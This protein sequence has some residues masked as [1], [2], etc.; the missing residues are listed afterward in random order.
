MIADKDSPH[1]AGTLVVCKDEL[2]ILERIHGGWDIP[3]GH[4]Q[5]GEQPVAAAMREC[6]EETRIKLP[7]EPRYIGSESDGGQ[8]LYC[9]LHLTNTKYKVAISNEHLGHRWMPIK[10]IPTI[11]PLVDNF[12]EKLNNVMEK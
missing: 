10:E 1:L 6:F 2:L 8:T 4:I 3:K 11:H 5:V 12:V 7:L 9:F